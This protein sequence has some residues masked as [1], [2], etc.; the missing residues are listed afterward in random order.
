MPFEALFRQPLRLEK[1]KPACAREE[2]VRIHAWILS[3][4]LVFPLTVSG[5]T[6]SQPDNSNQPQLSSKDR[7]FL[8]TLASEDQSEINLANLALKKTKDPKVQQYA[9]SK[10]L[11]ADPEM[12]QGA[13]QIAQQNHTT[14]SASPNATARK[15]FQILSQLSGT[16][17]DRAY[18]GYEN[19]QQ[20][21]D[22]QVVQGEVGST[23]NPQVRS[24]AQQE[25]T[26]VQQASQAVQQLAHSMNI[27]SRP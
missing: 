21:S 19:R 1:G 14:I 13:E 5:Q 20:A 10:I 27:D 2:H 8:H 3:T 24:Y 7:L 11:G 26:P 18:I 23:N 22:L 12:K 16:D 17:F 9:K 4:A 6:P 25:V 15:Q